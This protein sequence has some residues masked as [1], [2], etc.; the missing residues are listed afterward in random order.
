[1]QTQDIVNQL[2]VVTE[3]ILSDPKVLRNYA[4]I[5]SKM[6]EEL[7]NEGFSSQEAQAIVENYKPA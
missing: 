4:K 3:A 6:K 2:L 1:M 7:I 5:M